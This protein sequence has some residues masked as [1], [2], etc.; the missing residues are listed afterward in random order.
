MEGGAGGWSWREELEG[1]AR[2]GAGGGARETVEKG[3][4]V[5]LG[6][7]FDQQ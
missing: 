5:E 7:P 3:L 6:S 2:G 4:P 1:G